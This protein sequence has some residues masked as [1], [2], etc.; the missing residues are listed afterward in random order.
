MKAYNACAAI[1]GKI[2]QSR[3]LTISAGDKGETKE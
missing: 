2:R 3:H 1:I